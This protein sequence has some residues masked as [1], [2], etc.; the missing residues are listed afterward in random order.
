M[1]KELILSNLCI[2]DKR[3]P[4]CFLDDDDEI[5][6]EVRENCACDNCFYGRKELAELTLKLLGDTESWKK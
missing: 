4:D 3:N 6:S 5:S 1:N 2:Y